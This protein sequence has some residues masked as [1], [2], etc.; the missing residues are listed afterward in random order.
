[1]AKTLIDSPYILPE[2]VQRRVHAIRHV[3]EYS[4]LIGRISR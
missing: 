4:D 2:P 1:M 3:Q